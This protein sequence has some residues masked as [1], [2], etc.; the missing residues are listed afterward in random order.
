MAEP[1]YEQMLAIDAQR[2]YPPHVEARNGPSTNYPVDPEY[3]A[4]Y[5]ERALYGEGRYIKMILAGN[6]AL[7]LRALLTLRTHVKEWWWVNEGAASYNAILGVAIADDKMP[8]MSEEGLA[9]DAAYLSIIN[10]WSMKH[11]RYRSMLSSGLGEMDP[12]PRHLWM[13]NDDMRN[14]LDAVRRAGRRAEWI[15]AAAKNICKVTELEPL[16]EV[17]VQR[18][19]L[20][21]LDECSFDVEEDEVKDQGDDTVIKVED[22]D[23]E[24]MEMV[25]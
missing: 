19:D 13:K 9:Q 22:N 6:E 11:A 23:D 2:A 25:D 20:L 3:S 10:D 18:S 4:A 7:M 5:P 14:A 15:A 12:I 17:G 21:S 16:P 1:S 8:L 24:A